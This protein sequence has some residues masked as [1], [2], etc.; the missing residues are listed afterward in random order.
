MN[1]RRTETSRARHQLFAAAF[2]ECGQA[3]LCVRAALLLVAAALALLAGYAG[4]DLRLLA[5]FAIGLAVVLGAG[6]H[7]G[8]RS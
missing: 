7:E 1:G 2:A 3:R 6:G 4:V 8:K 5:V